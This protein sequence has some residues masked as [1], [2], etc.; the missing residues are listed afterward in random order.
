MDLISAIRSQQPVQLPAAQQ[1]PDRPVSAAAA[2][3]SKPVAETIHRQAPQ[4]PAS[5]GAQVSIR[6]ADRDDDRHPAAEAR[7][8]AQAARDAYIKA[9]IAAGVS[10]LPLP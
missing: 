2:A 6:L 5:A 7:A 3:S 1:A 4:P 9:S 10:P 8:A